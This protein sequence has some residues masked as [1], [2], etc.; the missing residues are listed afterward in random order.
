MS[1]R[2]LGRLSFLHHPAIV[3][4]LFVADIRLTTTGDLTHWYFHCVR[5]V[6]S[7]RSDDRWTVDVPFWKVHPNPPKQ[8]GSPSTQEA[9]SSLGWVCWTNEVSRLRLPEATDN[10]KT[11][12]NFRQRQIRRCNDGWADDEP[13]WLQTRGSPHS[14]Y[15]LAHHVSKWYRDKE[16]FRG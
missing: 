2:D 14:R 4:W 5:I 6:I 7:I 3:S 11:D 9:I 10:D 1:G 15:A 13:D 12:L 16:S 8:G